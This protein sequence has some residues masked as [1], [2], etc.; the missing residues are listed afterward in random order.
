VGPIGVEG[1]TPCWEPHLDTVRL[2]P[3]PQTVDRAT[4]EPSGTLPIPPIG[5]VLTGS[6]LRLNGLPP[7][8]IEWLPSD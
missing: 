7:L 5:P 2:P 4:A 3:G 1:L 6:T 8:S